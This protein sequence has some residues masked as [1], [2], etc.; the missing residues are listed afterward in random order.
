MEL[1][2]RLSNPEFREHLAQLQEISRRRGQGA[3]TLPSAPKRQMPVSEAIATV[4]QAQGDAPARMYKIHEAVEQFLGRRVPR[5]TIK[6][7]LA[8]SRF[9]R[10]GRGRYRLSHPPSDTAAQPY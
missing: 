1:T 4:L 9:E 2:G 7:D 8:T 5:S 10:V 3:I 6:N